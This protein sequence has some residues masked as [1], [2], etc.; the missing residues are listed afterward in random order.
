M[1][2]IIWVISS[3]VLILAVIAIRAL[4]GR[5][6]RPGLRYALWGLVL[7]RLLIPGTLF[8]LPVSVSSVA[9]RAEVIG[10]YEAVRGV[11]AIERT[12]NGEIRLIRYHMPGA[13]APGADSAPET[14]VTTAPI[15]AETS[16]PAGEAAAAITE[17]EKPTAVPV[18]S[19]VIRDAAP[20]RYERMKSAIRLRDILRIVW[21]AGV[22]A[23]ASV[24]IFANVRLYIRL[25]S[26]RRRIEADCKRPVYAVDGLASS[27]LFLG[28]IY[29]SGEAARDGE[30][31]RCVLAHETA[32]YRHGD[33]ILSLLRCAAL[34]LHWYNPLVWWAAALSV[35]D[36][37][38][39]ADAGAVKA[40]GESEREK[41]G[42]TLIALSTNRSKA[43]VI[44]SAA[45]SMNG[46]KR[47]LR[48]RIR[49][50]SGA[51]RKGIAVS[52]VM[53][54]IAAFVFGC[55]VA[56]SDKKTEADA[57]ETPTAETEPSVSPAPTETPAPE[58]TP[59]PDAAA[60]SDP[61]FESAFR[62]KYGFSGTIRKEDLLG[63]TE[64]DLSGCGLS[65][66][67][68]IAAF[69]ELT[70]LDL[71]NNNIRNVNPLAAL[72]KLTE[73]DLSNN[74]IN[75]L[76]GIVHLSELTRLDLGSNKIVEES[77]L[78]G[79]DLTKLRYLDIS[80]NMINRLGFCSNMAE[81]ETLIA[82][83]NQIKSI[84]G[85]KALEK[86]AH[87]EINSNLIFDLSV[88][89]E[90]P[91][92]VRISA[93][94][95]PTVPDDEWFI[96][97][98]WPYAQAA[99]ET[100]DLGF[101]RSRASVGMKYAVEPRFRIVSFPS[102]NGWAVLD[103]TFLYGNDGQWNIEYSGVIN[104][105]WL[106]DGVDTSELDGRIKRAF[107]ELDLE[108]L[109]SVTLTPDDLRSAGIPADGSE[110]CYLGIMEYLAGLRCERFLNCSD[111]NP[112]KCLEAAVT[113]SSIN[114]YPLLPGSYYGC[115]AG[116][117]F[118]P[119]DAYTF[120]ASMSGENDLYACSVNIQNDRFYGMF[121]YG[122]SYRITPQSDG[123][124][125]CVLDTSDDGGMSPDHI[126]SYSWADPM[127]R[128][129][130]SIE[131]T[132]DD[133]LD[134]P[135]EGDDQSFIC[136]GQ[137]VLRDLFGMDW[138]WF[139]REYG[140]DDWKE[141][142]QRLLPAS[143]S[144]YFRQEYLVM[145]V[146]NGA[147]NAP[148]EYHDGFRLLLGHQRENSPESFEYCLGTLN[149]E[150]LAYISGIMNGRN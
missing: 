60:F 50:I 45:T 131:S 135:G 68:D 8:H 53:L 39:F 105:A 114:C 94:G 14:A 34:S 110:E 106:A 38:L 93:D 115:S 123:S 48:E 73:L 10:D 70:K 21:L 146:I 149:E 42:L 31:L 2:D 15:G 111:D 82:N 100:L 128:L 98:A 41:Y 85:L 40:L 59:D 121:G 97:R 26:R 71:S 74:K 117:C 127:S 29:V 132:L 113:G 24:F 124:F 109:R 80:G 63:F 22:L 13:A 67:S 87:L 141:L 76:Y 118:V 107:K 36:S 120:T 56:G 23:A 54:L 102:T 108:S 96:E 133:T 95:N 138:N 57:S 32:H 143:V 58:P 119:V 116:M 5:K 16:S 72:T 136:N 112:L 103:V 4:F 17:Q 51:G 145:Y 69:T 55:A 35:R 25:R 101:E 9:E 142:V 11:D 130:L 125:L 27:C 144:S 77:I 12:D 148:E 20:E 126:Y 33:H 140:M 49:Q 81:L 79:S 19:S 18:V 61:A 28:T 75:W 129:P 89:D 47:T 86:L 52:I 84:D 43:P 104:T 83:D 78:S 88:L 37:E 147:L 65:D 7:V 46:K 1:T 44:L 3:S 150:E 134:N 122:F 30:T 91:T 139:G 90:L 64:L 66:I 137:W 6:M 62:A 99:N 92:G